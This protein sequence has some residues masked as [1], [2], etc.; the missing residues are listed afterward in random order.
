MDKEVVEQR[1][2]VRPLTDVGYED[3]ASVGGKSASLGEMLRGLSSAGVR[4][5]SGFSTTVSA[6]QY[7]VK[8]NR[9]DKKIASL[10]WQYQT[11]QL[12][13]R[14]A[15]KGIRE[16]ILEKS[17]PGKIKEAIGNAYREL[18]AQYGV[19]QMSVA[20]R[21]SATSEDQPG[22]SFA[23]MLDTH[24]NVQGERD[25]LSACRRCFASLFTDRAIRYREKMGMDALGS[26]ICVAVQRM[27]RSDKA[28]VM[29]SIAKETGL[30]AMVMWRA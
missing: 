19:T 24:L 17:L 11:K 18:C 22:A 7:F 26:S 3:I 14:Q 20:V 1:Q 21:S 5:P 13:L 10:L 4:V 16:S 12:T 27:I 30:P 28:G 25:L 2:Y 29:F 6:Y 23:G 9:L 8:G 15:G